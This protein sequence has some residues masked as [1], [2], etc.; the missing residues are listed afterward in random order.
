[1]DNDL[2]KDKSIGQI[3]ET[4]NEKNNVESSNI[5]TEAASRIADKPLGKMPTR[6][7]MVSA[8]KS[9]GAAG[10]AVGAGIEA[11]S[12]IG[13]WLTGEKSVEKVCT[14]AVKSAI[15]GSNNDFLT[16]EVEFTETPDGSSIMAVFGGAAAVAATATSALGLLRTILSFGDNSTSNCL[17]QRDAEKD[18]YTL[19]EVSEKTGL[20]ERT[21]QRRLKYNLL[22]AEMKNGK[23]VVS[24][25]ELKRF[26][27]ERPKHK[28]KLEKKDVQN[29][30]Q[31]ISQEVELTDKAKTELIKHPEN[32]KFV[33]ESYMIEEQIIALKIKQLHLQMQIYKNNPD[34]L[35]K[36]K[37]AVYEYGAKRVDIQNSLNSLNF[38]TGAKPI[39][40]EKEII[41]SRSE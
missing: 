41:E 29:E 21:L 23:Y 22:Q 25:E 18:E 13:D 16:D 40:D 30:S 35:Q 10:A 26:I 37:K 3:F 38:L 1:M 24:N 8:A 2:K 20:S 36:I 32:V 14:S 33:V 4:H 9:G 11:A 34:I 39:F 28:K 17:P 27:S 7:D 12:S 6:F 31:L 5:S 15:A 19:K